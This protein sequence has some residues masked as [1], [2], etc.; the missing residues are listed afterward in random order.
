M[1]HPNLIALDL[2]KNVIEVTVEDLSCNKIKLNKKVNRKRLSKFLAKQPPTTIAME[3]C[4]GAHYWTWIA[5]AHGHE[6]ILLPP[7]H[8][9]PYRQGHKTDENDNEAILAAAKRPK[10]KEAVKKT[11]EQLELQVL[12]G[13]RRHYS[14]DKRRWSQSIRGQLAEFGVVIPKSYAAL[15]RRVP[16]V[17]EDAENGLPCRLRALIHRQ[18]ESFLEAERQ[19]G[20]LEREVTVVSRQTDACRRLCALEGVGP[21]NAIGLYTRIGNGQAFHDG[22][23]AS[24]YIGNTPQQHS[25]S[26]VANIGHIRKKYV[27]KQFRASLLQG[28]RSVVYKLRHKPPTTATQ[29]WLK[30]IIARRGE[31]VAIVALANKNTRIA[32]A[33][34]KTGEEYVPAA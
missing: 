27:D 30:D 13:V 22:R 19:L 1:S 7:H 26:G 14:D 15:K 33:L 11:P 24:A 29:R 12:L 16:E 32:W 17:L 23:Q 25:T 4:S 6:V 28:A 18:Y 5:E 8:V 31:K 20:E 34:L 21:V 10:R 2:A 3:A 9:A